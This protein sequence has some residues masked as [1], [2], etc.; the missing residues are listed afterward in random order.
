MVLEVL[1]HQAVRFYT[2]TFGSYVPPGIVFLQIFYPLFKLANFFYQFSV[3]CL[4]LIIFLKN[5]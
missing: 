5:K 2:G 3:F 4:Q 1:F